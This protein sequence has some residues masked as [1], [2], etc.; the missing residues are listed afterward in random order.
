MVFL[1]FFHAEAGEVIFFPL[2][3]SHTCVCSQSPF[4]YIIIYQVW[5]GWVIPP[6][7]RV[8]DLLQQQDYVSAFFG[9]TVISQSFFLGMSARKFE[10]IYNR[11]WKKLKFKSPDLE[12]TFITVRWFPRPQSWSTSLLSKSP[13]EC[14]WI[15]KGTVKSTYSGEPGRQTEC[16]GSVSDTFLSS[17]VNSM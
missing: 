13:G 8:S 14:K 12:L 15:A 6:E 4:S 7:K 2:Q 17:K 3:Q 16:V 9:L 11:K 5:A 1:T 10:G